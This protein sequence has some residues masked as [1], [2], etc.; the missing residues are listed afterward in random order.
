MV[1]IPLS[2]LIL[3]DNEDDALLLVRELGKQG[4]DLTWERAWTAAAMKPLLAA[5]SWDVILSDYSMPGFGAPDALLLLQES[6]Q[7][8]PFIVVSGTVGENAAV[9]AMK[10]GA[11]DYLMKGQ[12]ARLG[13]AIEREI[14]DAA[15]RREHR[16]A[17]DKVQ[18]LNRVLRAVRKVSQLIIRE[19]DPV[20]LIGEGC[21]CLVET[22]GYDAA[23]IALINDQGKATAVAGR[24]YAHA[25]QDLA[26]SLE[27]GK[28]PFCA[29]QA[30]SSSDVVFITEQVGGCKDCV[31]LQHM[32]FHKTLTVRIEHQDHV[33]GL[34][35]VTLLGAVPIDESEL[36]L[37]EEV[38]GDLGFAL[39]SIER[40]NERQLAVQ[41]LKLEKDFNEG[42]IKTA[43]AIVL[44]L[45]P[46]GRIVLYNPYLE[47]LSGHKLQD[48]R[49]KDW[50]NTFSSGDRRE[51]TREVFRH[52]IEGN[53]T[54][55]NIDVLVTRDGREL[56][57]EWYD[58]TLMDSEGKITGLLC[59]GQEVTARQQAEEKLRESQ[60]YLANIINTIGDPVFVKDERFCF[61]LVNTALCTLLGKTQQELIGSTGGA[62]L[63]PEEMEHF[64]SVDREVL[65]TGIEDISEEKLTTPDRGI[66]NIVTKKTRYID[67]QDAKYIVGVIRDMTEF[68][69]MQVQL[70]QSD[71]LASMGMLAAGVA[72]EINNPLAYVLY[73]L[74]SLTDDLPKLSSALSKCL[75][76]MIQRLGQD[77]WTALMGNDLELLNPLM[78]ED[79]RARFE[80]ALQGAHRIRDVARGLG[81]FSRVE[82][83][84]MVAVD[85]MHV[86]EVALNM[87]S[88][89][90][91][92]RARLVKEYGKTSTI[93][94]NDGKLS[95]VFLNLL[96]NAA[97]SIPD[98]EFEDNEIRVRTWQEG[99]EVFT[100]IRDTGRGI[101]EA[102]LPHL[103]EPFFTTKEI[104]VG[105]GLGL[106]ISKNIIEG[107][108]GRID[109]TSELGAG[110]SFVVR[111]PV[112]QAEEPFE[113]T[114]AAAP[115]RPE[116]RGRILVVDDEV[117]IRSAM[118][119]MLNMHEVVEAASGEEGRQLLEKDQAFDLIL[120]DMMMPVVSGVEIHRW[121]VATHPMLADRLVFVTGGAFTPG[122]R[123]YLAK[124]NNLRLEKPFDV[125]NFKKIVNELILAHQMKNRLG[126]PKS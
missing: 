100:E 44:V 25:W 11:H 122:A 73:N 103:F 123:E 79:I 116:L 43:Q 85:L 21:E 51:R 71:R 94:A 20:R 76:R 74:E 5:K 29:A 67:H 8:L 33:Y 12:L 1:G 15:I 69:L 3:E 17:I 121:L 49:G 24:G 28:L 59:L 45:D 126:E 89:E 13:A 124:V 57:I 27:H 60:E 42:L 64:L 117:G 38:A 108:G 35:A 93:M 40:E 53:S 2:A 66:Y 82:Q 68:K 102:H 81:T 48:T 120:C 119:R 112:N 58:K 41:A 32:G 7:D 113:E 95:Q 107:Y 96:I 115:A 37:F 77:D 65:S 98:G 61:T 118:R 31:I 52:A 47:Q 104:G 16:L 99:D 105:T 22:S 83:D 80:D 30:L 55:G 50:F 10:N 97:H 111:L 75:D 39:W 84:K 88:N 34:M 101:S 91:K 56:L 78:I 54:R 70:T 125:A 72:H 26:E 90:I 114:Q 106:P 109:V 9:A 62:F 86:V 110:T 19:K 14:R 23:W 92:Y 18:H 87:V 6:G 63:S 46:K 4:F 36:S